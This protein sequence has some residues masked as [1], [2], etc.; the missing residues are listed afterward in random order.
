MVSSQFFSAS[1]DQLDGN[2]PKPS[3]QRQGAAPAMPWLL[4]TLFCNLSYDLEQVAG[5]ID[6][7]LTAQNHC[8]RTSWYVQGIV[9]GDSGFISTNINS[10]RTIQVSRCGTRWLLGQDHRCNVTLAQPGVAPCHAAL[11]F[12][13]RRGFFISDLGGAEGTW[14][15]GR[16]LVPDERQYLQDGDLIKLGSLRFEFLYQHCNQPVW[17]DC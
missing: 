7:I 9:S 17:D 4:D 1:A 15:N 11:N 6:P 10:D 13:P 14:V 2:A 16:R 12:E 3:S 8:F 5:I